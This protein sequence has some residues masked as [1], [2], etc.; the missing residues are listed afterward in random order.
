SSEEVEYR[1]LHINRVLR[2]EFKD[3]TSSDAYIAAKQKLEADAELGLNDLFEKT[4]DGKTVKVKADSIKTVR[5]SRGQ[6]A[7]LQDVRWY[8]DYLY[9]FWTPADLIDP[10]EVF[11]VSNPQ[12]GTPHLGHL[13]FE[14]WIERSFP[15]GYNGR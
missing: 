5:D 6:S 4:S 14:G 7:S 9:V 8:N 3:D 12:D 10:L 13:E 2:Y 11:D 1:K 15:I